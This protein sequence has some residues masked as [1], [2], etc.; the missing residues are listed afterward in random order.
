MVWVQGLGFRI[1]GSGD[2]L[3]FRVEGGYSFTWLL[4]VLVNILASKVST[5]KSEPTRY[6][7]EY[8]L[9]HI[10][11]YERFKKQR[12]C[13]NRSVS[14]VHYA[15]SSMFAVGAS[16]SPHMLDRH[17][18]SK[19]LNPKHTTPKHTFLNPKAQTADILGAGSFIYGLL[20]EE[21]PWLEKCTKRSK[22]GRV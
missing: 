3:G 7:K 14:S 21:A 2:C 17:P 16:L 22:P 1:Q 12:L 20:R 19:I 4:E 5:R 8:E 10:L 13:D 9:V 15:D 18:Q 6:K 11:R